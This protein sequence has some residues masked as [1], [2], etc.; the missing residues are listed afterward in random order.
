MARQPSPR[1]AKKRRRP[2][3]RRSQN[4]SFGQPRRMWF[5]L[6]EDRILLASDLD[7]ALQT[8]IKNGAPTA[9]TLV[10]ALHDRVFDRAIHRTQPLIGNALQVKDTA[11]DQLK[12]LSGT[13]QT[14][15]A[16]LSAQAEVTS[17]NIVSALTSTLGSLLRE[18][19]VAPQ[20]LNTDGDPE[21]EEA[22]YTIKLRGTVVERPVAFALGLPGVI[23]TSGGEVQVS[24]DYEADLVLGFSITTGVFLDTAA[25]TEF[26]LELD[27][28]T[29]DL[30]LTGK[31]GILPVEAINGTGPQTGIDATFFV[32]FVDGPDAGTRL[33]TS[34][35]ASI[36]V[37]PRLVGDATVNLHLVTD[38][39]TANFPTLSADLKIDWHVDESP[40]VPLTSWGEVPEVSFENVGIDVGS[41]FSQLAQPVFDQIDQALAP[42]APVLD[43][44]STPVPVLSDI[45]GRDVTIAELAA[46]ALPFFTPNPDFNVDM[47]VAVAE[48][49]ALY[50]DISS[51]GASG[52]MILGSFDIDADVR[53]LPSLTGVVIDNVIQTPMS[54]PDVAEFVAST[55]SGAFGGDFVFPI[56]E[57][58]QT[59]FDL[60]LGRDVEIF[61][62]DLPVLS[63][64][65]EVSAFFPIFGFLGVRIA[66]SLDVGLNLGFGYDSSGLRQWSQ[67]NFD[68]AQEELVF[69][70]FFL[71]DR[72]A[73][74]DIPEAFVQARIEVTASA[75]IG[76]ASAGI[77]GALIATVGLNL[78][79]RDNDGRLH[80]SEIQE[81]ILEHGPICG[82]F[83][84]TGSLDVALTAY[85]EVGIGPF[86]ASV[87]IDI[88]TVRLVD[89]TFDCTQGGRPALAELDPTT[90]ELS[91]F[92]GPLAHRRYEQ[93]PEVFRPETPDVSEVYILK[94]IGV[95]DET[96]LDIIQVEAFGEREVFVGVSSITADGGAGNDIIQLAPTITA[97]AYLEGGAG[98]D[99]LIA[100]RGGGTV[101]GGAGDDEIGG[102]GGVLFLYGDEDNDL[103]H[104]GSGAD[105][106][107]GGDGDDIIFGGGEGDIISGGLGRDIIHGNA[108]NDF[109]SGNEGDDDVRG[110]ED[111][112]TL[113]GNEDNDF[114]RGGE[115]NNTVWGG[116][117]NDS[118]HTLSGNDTIHGEAG[119]DTIYSGAGN[120]LIYGGAD[121]DIIF[122]EEGDD[123]VYGGEGNDDI[124]GGDGDDI[125][126]GEAGDDLI[127]GDA[128]ND[129][130]RGGTENDTLHGG[131]GDDDIWGEDGNDVIHGNEGLDTLRGQ[132][133]D[134]TIYGDEDDDEIYGDAGA[135]T[136]HG[137]YGRDR[138]WGGTENDLIFGDEGIDALYGEAG[139]D[140]VHG[141]D[142]DD[143][144]EGGIGNDTLYGDAGSD[145][146]YGGE[147]NDFLYGHNPLVLPSEDDE[148]ADFLYG[149]AGDDW[150]DGGGGDD[151]IDGGAGVDT[152]YGSDGNDVILA[153][154]GVGDHLYGGAGDD[155]IVGSDDGADF[156][157]NFLDTIYF[158]DWIDA[159]SGNDTV[160]GLG[161]ADYL[162]GGDGDDWINSGFGSDWI[163]GGA[164]NDYL[165]AGRGFGERID[166]EDGEDVIYGSDEGNDTLSGGAGRDQIY[167]QGGNDLIAG[168]A[169]DDHLDG[170]TGA[171]TIGGGTENDTLYA[172]GGLGDVL[173]GGDGSDV[174]HASQDAATTIMGG[175]GRDTIYGYAGS[176]TLH[177]GAGDDIIDG[178]TGDDTIYGDGG[179][180]L[181]RGGANHD[182]LYGHNATGAGDDNAVDYIYG[183]FGTERNEAGSGRDRLFGQGGNDLLYGEG[184][185]DFIDAGGGA[186]NLV[187]YGSGESA[188][189][190]NFVPP[191]PTAPPAIQSAVGITHAAAILPAGVNTQ[192]RW[193]ELAGSG[194][195][196]GL[197]QSLAIA[198]EPSLVVDASGVM[199]AAWVDGRHGNYEIYV[200]KHIPGVGWQELAGGAGFSTLSGSASEG[201]VSNTAGSSRRPSLA[202]GA[203]GQPIVAWTEYTGSTSNIRAAKYDPAANAGQGGWVALGTSLAAGGVSAT[204]AADSPTVLVTTAGPVVAWLDS[205][206]GT[207]QVFAKRFSAGAWSGLGGAAFATGTGVSQ[208]TGSVSGFAATTD[209]TKVAI[210]WSAPIAG[211]S[212]VFLR[213][214]SGAVWNQ[215]GGSASGNGV[216][217]LAGTNRTPTAAY[218]SGTLF[219][220]WQGDAQVRP[221]IYVKRFTGGTWQ[222]V[223]GSAQFGVSAT[224]GS[225]ARPRLVSG[226]GQLHLAWADDARANRTGTSVGIF[227]KRWNGTSFVADF[228]MDARTPG[229]ASTAVV[230]SL[231]LTV[232]SAGRAL[233]SWS[234]PGR[235][236]PQVFMLANTMALNGAKHVATAA[237][238]VQFIL[239]GNDLG[240]GDSIEIGLDATA[241][242]TISPND[243]GVTI[244]G[245]PGALVSGPISIAGAFDVT[246]QAI[247]ASG[248]VTFSGGAR[249]AVVGSVLLAGVSLA[250]ASDAQ[251]IGN[252]VLG[253]GVTISGGLRPTI[254][255]NTI[256]SSASGIVLSG[257]SST[258]VMIR[259]NQITAALAGIAVA[260][261]STGA[262][263]ENEVDGGTYALDIQAAFTG[264]V[265][266]NDFYGAAVGV[267]YAAAAGL[268]GNRI[269]DN[270]TGV[271]STV[272]SQASGFGFVLPP[273]FA[274]VEPNE[275]FANDVGVQLTGV[276]QGQHVFDNQTGVA[277]SG[278]LVPVDFEHANLIEEN[279]VGVNFAGPVQFNR[280]ASNTIG[281]VA[282]NAQLIAH[283][284]IYRNTQT[285]IHVAGRSDVRIVANTMYSPQGDLVRID[286]SSREVQLANNI[287]WAQQG[288]DIYVANNSQTGF[289]SD[290]NLLHASGTGKLVHWSGFDF[291]DILDWQADV[292]AF[293]LHSFG[294]T[295][296]NPGWSEPR[297]LGVALDDYQTLDLVA[298]QRFSNPAVDAGDPR[299]DLA[300]APGAVNLLANGSF[301]NLLAGWSTNPGATTQT[302]L[303]TP[304]DGSR[305]FAG[306]ASAT[307]FAEQ[308]V[309][310]LASGFTP[311]DLVSQDLVAVFGG[312]LRSAAETPRDLG[313]VTLRFLDGS[314]ALLHETTATAQNSADRWELVGGRV[315]VPIGTRYV[316][317]RFE[318]V[319]LSGT[320]S[321]SFLDGAFV[322]VHSDRIAPDM[323]AFGNTYLDSPLGGGVPALP[324]HIALRSPDLYVD[325]ERDKPHTIRWDSY[326]NTADL[327]VRIDLY[328]DGPHGPALVMT[329]AAS[330]PDDGEYV[331]IPA[332]SGIAYGT[333]G[334]R[335]QIQLV[336]DNV[337]LDRGAESFSVPENTPDFFVNDRDGSATAG[338]N[339]HT[340]KLASEPKPLPNN[341]LRVYTVAPTHTF[342][343]DQGDY[344]LFSTLLVANIAGQGD[345]EGFVMTGPTGAGQTAL[346]RHA[347]P[348]FTSAPIVEL[349]DADFVTM[350]HLSMEGGTYGLLIRNDSQNF[351]GDHITVAH[352]SLDGLRFESAAAGSTLDHIT[353]TANGRYGISIEGPIDHIF[354]SDVGFNQDTGIRIAYGLNTAHTVRLEGNS[355][356]DNRGSGIYVNYFGPVVIGL[357]NLV[358][359]R[360][361][362]IRDNAGYGIE[363]YNSSNALIAGNTVSGHRT[364]GRAGI[365]TAGT[366]MK[367]VVF[368]N[369]AGIDGGGVSPIS[370]NRVYNNTTTGIRG[371]NV[372]G[373]VVYSNG[374]V[375]NPELGIGIEVVGTGGSLSNNIVYAN[376]GHGIRL[377]A[378]ASLVNN[379]VYQ[380]AGNA[381][382]IASQVSNVQLRNNILWAAGG[383][384]IFVPANAQTG[385]QSDYNLL[386][387]TGNGQIGS[388]QGAG[389]ATL[390]AWR[391][392][393]F[394]DLNSLSQDPLFVNLNDFHEQSLYGSFHGASLAP[395]W[396]VVSGLPEMPTGTLTIDGAQ[397]PA[398]DRGRAIDPYG[399]EVSP[400]GGFINLGAYGN[401]VFASLSPAQY[402]LV[403]LPDG[404]EIW[405]AGQSFPIRWR[406]HDSTGNVRIELLDEENAVE[407]VIAEPTPNDGDFVWSI[408]AGI[409]A[410]SYSVRVT[411]LDAGM[412][413][414][415]SNDLF[416]IPE[417]VSLYYVNDGAVLAG[418]WTTAPGN[419]ANNGLSAATPKASIRA[420]LEAYD[421]GPGDVIRVD[422]GIY[423]LT[424]NILITPD[425]SGVRIEGFHNTIL[426]GEPDP[427]GGDQKLRTI[428]NRG[429]T[430][431]G[432]YAI[433]F[434]GAD[435]VTLS[436]LAITG[437]QWGVVAL[438]GA[439]SDRITVESCEIYGNSF[440][441]ISFDGTNDSPLFTK[442]IVFLTGE[443]GGIKAVSASGAVVSRNTVFNMQFGIGIEVRAAFNA[444]L[445]S[446]VTDNSVFF[447]TYGII[448]T[449]GNAGNGLVTVS[450]N[451]VHTSRFVGINAG[452]FTLV[453]GNTAHHNPSIGI[454]GTDVRNNTVHDNFTGIDIG[455]VATNVA[456]G[457]RVFNNSV[458]G[459]ITS[460]ATVQ[461]NTVY[462]NNVGVRLS[463][464][465]RVV[466]NLLYDNYND[467]I[468]VW[469]G[470]FG[471]IEN[472]TIYQN[473]TG[474]AIQ[475]GGTHPEHLISTFAADRLTIANNILHVEQHYAM[476]F[477][478]DSGVGSAIDYNNLHITGTGKLARW[479]NR[480]FTELADWFYEL[481][482]DQHS[483]TVD[484][485]FVSPA[486]ADGNMGYRTTPIGSPTVIDNGDPG[487]S[488]SGSWHNAAQANGAGGEF[489]ENIQS[490]TARWLFNSSN[491]YPG[492]GNLFVDVPISAFWDAHPGLGTAT[493]SHTTSASYTVTYNTGSGN[494]DVP[495]N[496]NF[497]GTIA[498]ID[499][500]TG[501]N[502][503]HSVGALHLG[504]QNHYS[505]V[506]F[507]S[508]SLISLATTL[509]ISSGSANVIADAATAYGITVDDG[510]M[511]FNEEGLNW[512][513][514]GRDGD[515]HV[516]G[517]SQDR[518]T[519]SWEFTGLTPGAY[520]DVAALW[521]ALPGNS[522]AAEF[523]IFDGDLTVS[524]AVR[525]LL[526]TPTDFVDESGVRWN[527]LSIVKVTGDRLIV[528]LTGPGKL[529]AD[530]IRIQQVLGD[531]SADDDFHVTPSS[532]TIDAGNPIYAFANEPAPNGGRINIGHTGNTAEAT[533]SPAQF[534][535]VLAPNGLEKFEHNQQMSIQWRSFGL[536]EP[537]T[538]TIELVQSATNELTTI[539]E[540][541]PNDGEFAWT[542]PAGVAAGSYLIRVTASAGIEPSDDSDATFLIA[543][544]GQHYYVNDASL[545]GDAFTT[546][547]GNNANSG[548]T[549]AAPMASIG[550]LLA[551]YNLDAGDVIHVDA[552]TY[553]LVK[554][555]VIDASDSGVR[556]EGPGAIGSASVATLNRGSTVAGSYVIQLTGADDVT[557]D[558]FNITGG[559]YGVV[560]LDSIDSDRLVITASE[561]YDN[562]KQ[563]VFLGILNDDS[564]IEGN[565]FYNNRQGGVYAGFANGTIVRDNELFNNNIPGFGGTGITIISGFSGN[566]SI[567]SG[568]EVYGNDLGM[569]ISGTTLIEVTDNIVRNNFAGIRAVNNVIVSQNEAYLNQGYHG[570]IGYGI[571]ASSSTILDNVVYNN[572]RGIDAG[573]ATIRDNRIYHNRDT[574]IQSSGSNLI[575]GNSIYGHNLG[576]RMQGSGDAILNN[577]LYDNFNDGIWV[578]S[579]N[580]G[581]IENNTIYQSITGDAIQVGGPHPEQFVSTFSASNITIKN[582]IL[583]VGQGYAIN[584]AA[585]SQLGM[586]FDY[587][588]FVIA[589]TGKVGRWED[590]DFATRE[591][592]FFELG[593]DGHSLTVDPQFVDIDGADNVLGYDSVAGIDR[594]L[595]DNFHVLTTSLTIDAGD[596][597]SVYAAEP[598]PNGSRVNLGHTGNTAQAATSPS[599]LVQIL[600][601]NGLEK[602]EVGKSVPIE[603]HSDGLTATRTVALIDAGGS[604]AGNWSAD[605]YRTA[606]QTLSVNSP[607]N[608]SGVVNPAHA[609]TYQIGAYGGF[610]VG[611]RVAYD[612]PVS[613]GSYAIRLHFV[614]PFLFSP[615][616]RIFDIKLNGVTVR[617]GFDIYA[618][619]GGTYK[620]TTLT[621]NVAATG[622]LGILLEMINPVSSYGA[623]VTGIELTAANPAGV[624]NPTADIDFS[625]DGG[626]SW[627]PIASSIGMDQYGRGSYSWTPSAETNGNTALIRVRSNN[628]TFPEDVSDALFGV[629]NAGNHYYANDG[630]M[631]GDVF[632]SATGNNV[633]SGKSPSAP[634]L[635]LRALLAAYDLDA[636][637]VIHVDAGTYRLYQNLVID[638]PDS[639]VRIEGPGAVSAGQAALA[640][641][642]LNR[643]N[644]IA[645]NYAIEMR[646]ADDVTL[647]Y[648]AFIGG[649]FGI[650]ASATA[651]SDRLAISNSDVYGNRVHGI[652]IQAGNDDVQIIGNRAHDHTVQ[653]D[654]TGIVVEAARGWIEN[655]EVF[656]NVGGISATYFGLVADRITITGNQAHGN[657]SI[658]IFGH[659]QVLVTGNTAYEQL[660]TGAV[661][662]QV[663]S[664]SQSIVATDNVVYN[665]AIGILAMSDNSVSQTVQNNRAFHNTVGI[666]AY[667]AAQVLGNQVYSN[668]IGISGHP[669]SGFFGV[670]ANNLVYANANQGIYIERSFN[671]GGKIVNN[672]VY[673]PV[674]EA[675]RI[676]NASQ[677]MTLRN[678]V[679]WVDSGYAI[680]VAAN[681]QFNVSSNYN[682]IHL[683]LDPNAHAGF[684]NGAARHTLANWQA[685]SA[686]DA[687]SFAGDP[688]VVDRDG[689]DN[690]LGYR[691]G[692]GYD[693]GLDDNFLLRGGSPA[694][695]RGES[696]LTPALD[697]QGN[698]RVDDPGTPNTGTP[699]ALAFVD[700]G[701]HEFQGSS[702]D[703]TPPAIISTTPTAVHGAMNVAPFDQITLNF[704]EPLNSI[705]AVAAANYKLLSAGPNGNFGD[706]DDVLVTIAPA[707][708][709]G[710]TTVIID[711]PSGLLAPGQ[712]RLTVLGGLAGGLHDLSGLLLDGDANGTAGGDY[713]RNFTVNS[714]AATLPGD[715]DRNGI[716]D[717]NDR[718]FWL[719]R[720]GATSGIGLQ[721]DGNGSGVVDAADYG[722][723]RDNLGQSLPPSAAPGDYDRNETVNFDDYEHWKTHFGA[724][725]GTGLQADGNGN[726]VVDAADYTVWRDNVGA[727][728]EAASQ[729]AAI[730]DDY[731]REVLSLFDSTDI[732]ALFD[733]LDA[734]SSAVSAR[735]D[736]LHSGGLFA[737]A[738][739]SRP[740]NG[741]HPLPTR[742]VGAIDGVFSRWEPRRV[743]DSLARHTPP[744]ASLGEM[745][746]TITAERSLERIRSGRSLRD[747]AFDQLAEDSWDHSIE[748]HFSRLSTASAKA[749]PSS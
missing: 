614:E 191:T 46:T 408:P 55:Q 457:N 439:D 562:A 112:D 166:G 706:L 509:R 718:L 348:L 460:G 212:Q 379:T 208:A 415:T 148:A 673:Q 210:A 72:V 554:N 119:T 118:I 114:L 134:D 218:H 220:G 664:S 470:S 209:G 526:A 23:T 58:P 132:A 525:N 672:T 232:D 187:Y 289:W 624:P 454:L 730:A 675:I 53:T 87:S 598:A 416:D 349:S 186:S 42:V 36:G 596:P 490:A 486:G 629:A 681:S 663:R 41:F 410:G 106:I 638:A 214:F 263:R 354:D 483:Q 527:R 352:A 683:S 110:D 466:N 726:N 428:L 28:T 135:D 353:S 610:G 633:N 256:I 585:D 549:S 195:H 597:R 230:D 662:I 376:T 613:D 161:G 128:G 93:L 434:V 611:T 227:A 612:F 508:V 594:G 736:A 631:V 299:I 599:Q 355:I 645:G 273:G 701:A 684:W 741:A 705:D 79:D 27:V 731:E 430:S 699:P 245:V 748:R 556:I 519:A 616:Q 152:L 279:A 493:Y 201:G 174:L 193:S 563:G 107:Y 197:S 559:E 199:Y 521:T 54:H 226:G 113:F 321:D 360:G 670:I 743:I 395:V 271:A 101:R 130:I 133:G 43:L 338:D 399:N 523:S 142:G 712:Y 157:P 378:A 155:F 582:N 219:V 419:D 68:P 643:G 658:G 581:R 403:T 8:V 367:N 405:P 12:A 350:S 690:V 370:N 398:I 105:L 459:M 15:L 270:A 49:Y 565:R 237:A 147:G 605:A 312:R 651:D 542:V 550:A 151:H 498:S 393:T 501:G 377:G 502:G 551:A 635:S 729:G 211:G 302:A 404:G 412:Q 172:G 67:T 229:I 288:Y 491:P 674:G 293:D 331:W 592:W 124:H 326:N 539:V 453:T 333:H 700:W 474:D 322:R 652:Y 671:A 719:A 64:G 156:D 75:D 396:S 275:I 76:I 65:F 154:T 618:A 619:A 236:A 52:I 591:D 451:D 593:Y 429:N 609:A 505:Q 578:W 51:S 555:I 74:V 316:V 639:G 445:P 697:R 394:G 13:I 406:S 573:V 654:S 216:S 564:R 63:A 248:L 402:V 131:T 35:I 497:S 203:D 300:L 469:S 444:A 290:Y 380:T 557:L 407:L 356:H 464:A 291:T 583:R 207:T 544:A 734:S 749:S 317:Y 241:G 268:S 9:G 740:L 194:R 739:S 249:N 586:V 463:G 347:N 280:I 552:G 667:G 537:G 558:H 357:E 150:A 577:L 661:G 484:P 727:P 94:K 294:R 546:V 388:W 703:A 20:L 233:V 637:D 259:R 60:L 325:W 319:R 732:S 442:N 481:G 276:M 540:G 420:L 576:I 306:G 458:V 713:L 588:D 569:N 170:G 574:G 452:S 468:W 646:G 158:G 104:G 627:T 16:S 607:V 17:Q 716:V 171:D 223:G 600:S 640:T 73:G 108:G 77:G 247:T 231:G 179:A 503:S 89:F 26:R 102:Y 608:L 336:G 392:A 650:F 24:L 37:T 693:G 32:D 330:T 423:N 641:A 205:S 363:S 198:Q 692:D 676:D 272:A 515:Y 510:D 533:T 512:T 96:G 286:G 254:E 547:V 632:T 266:A 383:F 351:V 278:S 56:L 568:N 340:G 251:V 702:L 143:L 465:G 78:R 414:D 91:L 69:D 257:A 524:R 649:Q 258:D 200:A 239:D 99:R 192:G 721:A 390:A 334:L 397:S 175:A 240:P 492:S 589:G 436:H 59:V 694:I 571:S 189:P 253:T 361:N 70:G 630:S 30:A 213:E 472:N 50:Q 733:L 447:T 287:L 129:T 224:M 570:S 188:T 560:A 120:D 435:D 29:P 738:F 14:A 274:E 391:N 221:E 45:V 421:L 358:A 409:A 228:T 82:L 167:G 516:R 314:N 125:L 615:G 587:N 698:A 368:D 182:T 181:L 204:G 655:N 153:G 431:S 528:K 21:F 417:P 389:R 22:L 126:H 462:S 617:T 517:A 310:L 183:D 295:V 725:A 374:T 234:E 159:G 122:A 695:D 657:T 473:G 267:R 691:A 3:N 117:G 553:N 341:V 44:L 86:S 369:Y 477:A 315:Q 4:V 335:I 626:T 365:Y 320:T 689:S 31:L 387:A 480:D 488:V 580:G 18:P 720:F 427:F 461:A 100:G 449:G 441:G 265:E 724:T 636:G 426:T 708:A 344:A 496:V 413:S 1:R 332:N 163:R 244:I 723:W 575:V 84:F 518:G 644:T 381:V 499:Q 225:A 146:I 678:N 111:D 11:L 304:F 190:A 567:V 485:Q 81:N 532:P 359:G 666:R 710:G 149:Q 506:G 85:V 479:Q 538:A 140:V 478:A 717:Q 606:G 305:Y 545:A 566:K 255:R 572:D 246:L 680:Y 665:N 222:P 165:Y 507:V 715:Y 623:F 704:S 34:E 97:P 504:F 375:Q 57:T 103:I 90:R 88:L 160:H 309:D 476:N 590:R 145:R 531:N 329:L 277:G 311:A 530:A 202:I 343:I 601:P 432:A 561:I 366:I 180:D 127:Y 737:E 323:G 620:A 400:N 121:N 176:D 548:K 529:H 307:G 628:G 83:E 109:L 141:G 269:H 292:A 137:G 747:A 385:F 536:P 735:S 116:T 688:L 659:N 98:N 5:E 541:T 384:A 250:N 206:S 169:G 80:P 742:S 136:L 604:G 669:A 301:D 264:P 177:G 443:Q 282:Q 602:L 262:I 243:S 438:S 10:D 709:I 746:E 500:A 33:T 668:A 511:N 660:A 217:N 252:I 714:P 139:D 494:F 235:R 625:T 364:A 622:G 324:P 281:I 685:A 744:E 328:Q 62:L 61:R 138:I 467:G 164:G 337:V 318:S 579:V 7:P 303:P 745:A 489:L 173:D 19:I 475:I 677:G 372:T 471:R 422:A 66:G 433:Q 437:G 48:F 696:T 298:G 448:A 242:F 425:D 711:L 687:A 595:D 95:D 40:D 144:I 495:F 535:Q 373:N 424:A 308:S 487:F 38:L 450:G 342:H 123:T 722:V 346:L 682:L 261:A 382:H 440:G 6:L 162:V 456:Q 520:Y 401:T 2:P 184:D 196:D 653:F 371:Y 679:L 728:A 418:D 313:Q 327:P 185:D 339:R 584:V 648:L 297:F 656:G 71:R 39:G 446:F 260:A 115:G 522:S 215:I 686:Q 47:I 296:V 455:G 25:N 386:Y 543:S 534:V 92:T 514:A 603:W 707:Y 238:S 284:L 411:R 168:D 482:F 647:N 285:A 178:G 634:M 642:T 362:I 283:N 513:H 345:D 621:F